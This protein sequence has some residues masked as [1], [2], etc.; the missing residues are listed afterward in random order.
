[1]R[2]QPTLARFPKQTRDRFARH[3]KLS[4]SGSLWRK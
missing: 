3:D 2:Q 1:M 4:K